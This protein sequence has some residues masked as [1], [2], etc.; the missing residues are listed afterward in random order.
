MLGVMEYRMVIGVRSGLVYGRNQC[1]RRAQG[2]HSNLKN[3][4][5]IKRLNIATKFTR[6]LTVQNFGS[7]NLAYLQKKHNISEFVF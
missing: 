7:N 6:F 5:Q 1:R 3:S 2:D 4:R